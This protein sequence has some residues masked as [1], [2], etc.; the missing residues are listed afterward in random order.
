MREFYFD[1]S[2]SNIGAEVLSVSILKKGE[3]GVKYPSHL[4][5][6]SSASYLWMMGSSRGKST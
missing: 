4:E 2:G 3:C 5:F 1:K 6:D